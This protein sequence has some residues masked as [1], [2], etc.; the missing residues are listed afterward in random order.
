MEL[1]P[2]IQRAILYR[3]VTSVPGLITTRCFVETHH[4]PFHSEAEREFTCRVNG[5]IRRQLAELVHTQFNIGSAL[6]LITRLRQASI[7]PQLAV[8]AEKK[9][10]VIER[11]IL[12]EEGWNPDELPDHIRDDPDDFRYTSSKMEHIVNLINSQH[13]TSAVV[14]CHFRA[15]MNMLQELL[16]AQGHSVFQIHGGV[17]ALKR[18]QIIKDATV[19]DDWTDRGELKRILKSR[20]R[21]DGITRYIMK[22]VGSTHNVILIQAMAGSEGLNIQRCNRVYFS[23]TG[24]VPGLED[25]AI[26]RCF[27]IGQT[28]DVKVVKV[29]N[30]DKVRR[31]SKGVYEVERNEETIETIEERMSARVSQKR[32]RLESFYR[33]VLSEQAPHRQL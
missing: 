26:A 24:W 9:T 32:D 16:S 7:H 25:Q 27:R 11:A 22:F 3:P 21:H 29:V 1:P 18:H 6:Q 33:C 12:V 5:V 2:E 20:C 31:D 14:F 23:S 4:V 28:R 13:E 15:E 30:V 17:S 19:T 8:D 10:R